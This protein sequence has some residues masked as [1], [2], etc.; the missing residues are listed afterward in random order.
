M[1][2][3]SRELDLV[4]KVE[5]RIAAADSDAKLERVLNTYLAPLLLKLASSNK[6]RNKVIE[7]CQHVTTRTS[8]PSTIKLPVHALFKQFRDNGNIF[9]RHFDLQFIQ[10]GIDRLSVSD[11]VKVLHELMRDVALFQNDREA[12]QMFH[13]LLQLLPLWEIPEKGSKEDADLRSVLDLSDKNAGYLASTLQK[14]FLIETKGRSHGLSENDVS[15]FNL[16]KKDG[17]WEHSSLTKTKSAA[18]KFIASGAFTTEEQLLSAVVLS[19]DSNT[20]VSNIGDMMF[21]RSGFDLEDATAVTH[22]LELYSHSRPSLQTRILGLLSRSSEAATRTEEVKKVLVN[23]FHME[24]PAGLE[25]SRLRAQTLAFLT[26]VAQVGPNLGLIAPLAVQTLREFVES[27]GWPSSQITGINLSNPESEL[28]ANAYEAIG[29]FAPRMGQTA[30]LNTVRWLFTALRCDTSSSQIHLSIE[31]ALGRV[32]N[33]SVSNLDTQ[34]LEELKLLFHFN[35]TAKVGDVDEYYGFPTRRGIKY[36]TVRFSNRC[37]AFSDVEARWVDLMAIGSASTE[38]SEIADEGRK[39]LNPYWYRMLNPTSD[40][41]WPTMGSSRRYSFPVFEELV[42]F[43]FQDGERLHSVATSSS[44]F[45]H[46]LS[47]S[48]SFARNLLITKA[49]S[50]V[51][52]MR[53][54]DEQDWERKIDTLVETDPD[55]R[56][57]IQVALRRTGDSV[58]QAL[59]EAAFLGLSQG[60]LQCAEHLVLFCSLSSNPALSHTIDSVQTLHKGIISNEKSLRTHCAKLLGILVS[61]PDF[62]GEKRGSM[63]ETLHETCGRWSTAVGEKLNQVVGSIL[64]FGYVKSRLTLR[65]SDDVND[66]TFD[67]YFEILLSILKGSHQ[68]DCRDAAANAIGQLSLCNTEMRKVPVDEVLESLIKDAKKEREDAIL[69]LGRLTH[70]LSQGPHEALERVAQGLY[71]LHEIR[72]PETQFAIGEALSVAIAG[73]S[74]K[75]TI[76]DFDVDAEPPTPQM[77]EDF[78]ASVIDKVILDCKASK[79]TLRKASAIW[80]LSLV[81]YTGKLDFIQSRLR[82]CQAVFSRLLSDRDEVIQETGSRGLGLVFDMGDKGLKD[83]LVRDLVQS[84]TGNSVKMGGSVTEDTELFEPGALPTGEGSVTTY[85]DIMNLASEVGEPSLVYKFMN[86]AANNAIWSSRAAFGRFGLSSI[87]SDS[88]YLTKNKKFYPKLFRYRFDPNPNVQR[89]MNDIWTAIV[90]DSSAVLNENLDLILEDLLKSITG[91]EWR[92]RQ[93]SCDAIAD[94][95]QGREVDQYEKHLNQIWSLSFKVLDDIKESVR[96][97]AMKLCRTLTNLLIRNLEVGDGTSSRAQKMLD[98]A[99]PFLRDQLDSGAPAEVRS[100]AITTLIQILKKS[101]QRPIRKFAPEILET[102]LSSLSSLEHE[103]VNY[104]HLNAEKYGLTT[105]KIDEMRISGVSASPL[106]ESI[107]RCLESLDDETLE[108]AMRR[109]ESTMK[110]AIGLPSKVGCSRVLISLCVRHTILFRPHADRFVRLARKQL[111]D[112]NES[113][114]VSYSMALGYLSRLASEKEM[115]ETIHHAQKLYFTTEDSAHRAVSAEMLF[116]I[117]KSAND[118]F[119]DFASSFLPIAFIA[120]NDVLDQVKETFE[121]T[122]KDNVGGSRAVILYLSEIVGLV[123][124]NIDSSQWAVKHACALAIAD[125]VT[126]YEG[127]FDK[128]HATMVWPVLERALSGKTWEG[129]EKVLTAFVKF[130]GKSKILRDELWLKIK[131]IALREAKRQNAAYRPFGITALGDLAESNDDE[132]F[133][134]QILEFLEKCSE[135]FEASEDTDNEMDIDDGEVSSKSP[136]ILKALIKTLFQAISSP[137]GLRNA[138]TGPKLGAVLVSRAATSDKQD[139]R[140]CLYDGLSDFCQVLGK[141]D[142]N[143]RPQREKLVESAHAYLSTVVTGPPAAL[144]EAENEATRRK[145]AEAIDSYTKL[146][147][148]PTQQVSAW[149]HAWAKSERSRTVGTILEKACSRLG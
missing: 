63:L 21:K 91:K 90:K 83:D 4:G 38:R 47:A 113:V 126:S 124:Q 33:S 77:N 147:L 27:Q 148:Q 34:A 80:L 115:E 70:H 81:E 56:S 51:I 102:L 108:E 89:S 142:E 82:Q 8:A 15:F 137:A 78:V 50:E 32:M 11:R 29:L 60:H 146:G 129:K 24:A 107:E 101:P 40:G 143:S 112:R 25:G 57:M 92:V 119:R 141:Q 35:M 7:V 132:V 87:L 62:D 76:A 88:T 45:P 84:F 135:E 138:R 3:E 12:P 139:V 116:A 100:H 36:S 17:L 136:Q 55:A 58:L 144:H 106:T 105:A 86:L 94:L 120:K 5:F 67:L 109:L 65:R 54:S 72:R 10:Q 41:T 149:I 13:L 52:N 75:A 9:V 79:P 1:A 97:A 18:A 93:A 23:Q 145:R 125:L 37:F 118:R 117:S 114:S 26:W 66:Q 127:D 59:N 69:A 98:H 42:Q 53:V 64:A 95:I 6:V 16:G 130:V 96:S 128:A 2:D 19:A 43:V 30:D 140:F 22:L 46:A 44:Q 71:D 123:S 74:S 103:G 68:Q 20:T 31:Q 39:G 111:F 110:T 85:K 121:K 104:L 14:F 131:L 48:V 134:D 49:L 28:R 133:Y 61:H 99:M 122:W 73:F